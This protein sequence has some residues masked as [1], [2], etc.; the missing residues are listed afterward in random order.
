M[1]INALRV[2]REISF[3]RLAGTDG[4]RKA[5][6]ILL[7]YL[8]SLKLPITIE[9]FDI[10]TF[11][12]GDGTLTINDKEFDVIPFGLNEDCLVKGKLAYIEDPERM[13]LD[14]HIYKDKIV[15]LNGYNRK[16]LELLQ[17]QKVAALIVI[18][19][20]M[21]EAS[22]LSH[23]QKTY[24]D[25]YI[26]SATISYDN[27]LFLFKK[28][29]KLATLKIEQ[30]V[31]K[32]KAKNIIVDIKGYRPDD[33]LTYLVAHY[34][35]VAK[36]QGATDNAGG[37]VSLLKIAEYFAEYQ[38]MR[39]LRIILFSGEELGLLGSQHYVEAHKEEILENAG[40]VV[41]IDVS[42]DSIARTKAFVTGTR[43]LLGYSQGVT[44][45][46][47]YCIEHTLDIYSSDQM[48]FAKYEVPGISF[49]RV[50]GQG[51]FFIHTRDDRERF[52]S[53]EGLKAPIVA[54]RNLIKKILNGLIYPVKKEID[55]SLKEKIE[56]YLWN[57]NY[58]EPKLTWKPEY[59][60]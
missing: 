25:G 15:L 33:T 30:K 22:S 46:V 26:N 13:A 23:R 40:L 34:D 4:E 42:G 2:L 45:E 21:R 52:V 58:E 48:P 37:T 1:K 20:P 57:L 8:K 28:S 47:G 53:T 27:A 9:E 56:K 35:S 19:S 3:E 24:Q 7:S 32:A 17:K 43:E 41:N 10:N 44:R 60:K 18:G 36:T 39:D 59:K 5:A 16:A 31:Y 54:S 29:G 12:S 38:P 6:E 14:R 11:K 49:A 55:P 51:S 50:H